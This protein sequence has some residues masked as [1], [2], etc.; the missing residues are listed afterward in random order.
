M[1]LIDKYIFIYHE[2]ANNSRPRPIKYTKWK[3]TTNKQQKNREAN[4]LMHAVGAS[5]Q[6]DPRC[7][8]QTYHRPDQSQEAFTLQLVSYVLIVPTHKGRPG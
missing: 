8:W 6:L 7:R 2:A 1:Q 4:E 3:R 5:E